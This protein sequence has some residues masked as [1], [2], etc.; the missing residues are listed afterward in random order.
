MKLLNTLYVIMEATILS[1]SANAATEKPN[2]L[3]L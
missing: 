2:I 3:V 1:I